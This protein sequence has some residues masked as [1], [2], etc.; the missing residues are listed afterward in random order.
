M[1]IELMFG[2]LVVVILVLAFLGQMANDKITRDISDIQTRTTNLEETSKQTLMAL[3]VTQDE[4][5]SK[6]TKKEILD[7]FNSCKFYGS[8]NLS[9][10]QSCNNICSDPRAIG[11]PLE[12]TNQTC[13]LAEFS[14]RDKTQYSKLIVRCGFQ[15]AGRII[16]CVCC[17]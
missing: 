8:V 4:V 12:Q 17:K 5:R 11:G 14:E 2:A 15:E 7:T 10:G 9:E 6:T 3:S 13:V 1:K 16:N